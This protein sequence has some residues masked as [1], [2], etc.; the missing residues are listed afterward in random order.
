MEWMLTV[1]FHFQKSQQDEKWGQ[2]PH[3]E[4]SF[5]LLPLPFFNSISNLQGSA[6]GSDTRGHCVLEARRNKARNGD[7]VWVRCDPHRRMY[8]KML[9][10]AAGSVLKSCGIFRERYLDKGQRSLAWRPK[11]WPHF[12]STLL[13]GYRCGVTSRFTLLLSSPPWHDKLIPS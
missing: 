13:L 4:A 9:S 3:A 1:V 7:L 5:S 6:V 11:T 8:L 2:S 12:L 10:P